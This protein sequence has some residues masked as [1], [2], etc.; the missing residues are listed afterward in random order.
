MGTVL[1]A[2]R[3]V[4]NANRTVPFE[5]VYQAGV[6][7][8]FDVSLIQI[9]ADKYQLLHA[10]TVLLV[11]V[12]GQSGVRTQH[13]GQLVLGHGGV[14]LSGI[15]KAHL[16]S[17]LLKQVADVKLIGKIAHT[18]G[19]DDTLGPLLGHEPVKTVQIHGAAC[20]IY[21][22]ADAILLNLT[23]F[24]VVMVVM[25]LV[26]VV[27]LMLMLVMVLMLIMIVIV[28]IMVVVMLVLVIVVV[29]VIL[30]LKLGTTL[31]N[32]L[33]PG[34]AGGHV[35]KVKEVGVEY[36]VQVYVTVVT[37][38]YAGAGL[39]GANH[40]TY[41]QQLIGTYLGC[42]VQEHYVAELNL[43][44]YQILQVLLAY[45]LL[46]QVVAATELVT[47]AK[48][49]DH[50]Y[51]AVQL[52]YAVLG[53][54]GLHAGDGLYGLGNGAGLTDA[55]GLNHD[56]VKTVQRDDLVQLLHKVHLEGA[57]YA[58]VLQGYQAVIIHAYHAAL[59]YKAGIDIDFTYIVYN[60]RE[61]Y[62]L[63]VGQNPVQKGCLTAAQITGEQQ[64]RSFLS[65]IS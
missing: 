64:D 12:G 60:Y 19:A 30:M 10:V 37:L 39:Q 21:I 22:C 62:A 1:F 51:D 61:L 33:N 52:G 5:L 47:D 54:L 24:M 13:V 35:L 45:V 27:M 34:G 44:D 3:T 55:A 50:C 17:G 14:P 26:V 58:A 4:P 57:A 9:L 31:L 28:I 25:V 49:I 38:Q 59:L 65:H 36:V 48:G 41:T 40:L 53:V 16:L 7:F 46:Y 32:F 6:K 29:I 2:F 56:V 20:I 23:A 43:L 15:L 18:L 8:F 42:F 11:P 63:A